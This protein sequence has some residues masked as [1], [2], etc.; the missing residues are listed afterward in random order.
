MIKL[1][2]EGY[3]VEE[4]A[5]IFQERKEWN[6]GYN[7]YAMIFL[8]NGEVYTSGKLTDYKPDFHFKKTDFKETN[9]PF[10]YNINTPKELY[11]MYKYED[12]KKGD[13]FYY[14]II[15]KE[16]IIYRETGKILKFVKW[17]D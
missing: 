4:E 6:P 14:D 16:K 3:Y 15:S 10:L 7:V 9:T 1:S 12:G 5:T 17:D 2:T 8:E 13:K 11:C